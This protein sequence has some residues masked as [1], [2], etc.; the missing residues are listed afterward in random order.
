MP[1]K[2]WIRERKQ[3]TFWCEP[4]DY[5]YFQRLADVEGISVA[6]SFRRL[7]I[8]LI[9]YDRA[10]KGAAMC[11]CG[12]QC[13]PHESHQDGC[14]AAQHLCPPGECTCAQ[15]AALAESLAFGHHFEEPR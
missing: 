4:A 8:D 10:A 14:S 15:D 12:Q 6:E 2:D 9:E 13:P 7:M 5:E 3:V 1:T 11:T